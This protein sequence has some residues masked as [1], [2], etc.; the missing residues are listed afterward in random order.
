[1]RCSS[2]IDAASATS[3]SRAWYSAG[4]QQAPLGRMVE[5]EAV[6]VPLVVGHAS[7]TSVRDR[8]GRWDM[9]SMVTPQLC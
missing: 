7:G 1:M 5:Q 8:P 4:G 3:A 2:S 6:P 9:P